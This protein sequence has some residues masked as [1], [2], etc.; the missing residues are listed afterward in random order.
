M[1][2]GECCKHLA[3]SIGGKADIVEAACLMREA[4]VGFLVVFEQGADLK[5]P[6]GVLTDRDVVLEVMARE[7]SPRSVTVE[8]VMT[9]E[10]LI[11]RVGDQLTDLFQSMRL[12]GVRRVPVVD[13]RGALSG[14]IAVDDA[15]DV[16]T[17]L[18]CDLTGSIKGELAQE[19]RARRPLGGNHEP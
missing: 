19:G 6:I 15:I 8:D 10:P 3:V 18:L 11:A 7:V 9:R 12:A 2:V 1:T 4:H 17:Q 5:R 16:A 14:V 13:N